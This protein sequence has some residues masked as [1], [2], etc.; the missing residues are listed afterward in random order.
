MTKGKGRVKTLL[1]KPQPEQRTP[2]WFKQR[3][4]RVTASE[5]ASCLYKTENVCKSYVNQFGLRNFKY[6]KTPLNPYETREDYIIKKCAAFYGENVFKDTAFTLWGKKYEDVAGRLYKR[7]TGAKVYEFGLISHSRLKWLAASPDGITEDGVM[8]EIKCP[9]ARKIDPVAPPLYYWIQMQIQ[10]EVCDLQYCDFLEC[11]IEEFTDET[12]F[13]EYAISE[14]QE[15]GIVLQVLT[16]TQVTRIQ[17]APDT[18]DT[19][20]KFIYPPIELVT[21]T[22]YINWKNSISETQNI[23]P[24]YYLISKYN[25][26]RVPR[27]KDWFNSVKDEIKSTWAL[28]T[29]LQQSKEDFY[30]YK[31]SIH[32]LKSKDFY[33]RYEQTNCLIEDDSSEFMF[34]DDKQTES[35]SESKS[36]LKIV[37]NK[38]G[39]TQADE[40]HNDTQNDQSHV[41]NEQT[42]TQMDTDICYID[43]TTE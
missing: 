31:Q 7:L 41:K 12:A 24:T 21:K 10:L 39:E 5:A 6:A 36:H 8:L 38:N 34:G 20:L 15:I 33:E 29:K 30:K 17:G 42:D 19:E 13:L 25:I 35:E 43:T 1:K 16:D 2:E 27:D 26:M 28:V 40:I 9:K 37:Q 14:G 32:T 18:K 23:K 4:T 22:D 11:E 3:Q